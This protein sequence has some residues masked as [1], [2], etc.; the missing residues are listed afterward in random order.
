MDIKRTESRA[1]PNARRMKRAG[2]P[3]RDPDL[4]RL[5]ELARSV[6]DIREDRVAELRE[7][8]RSGTYHVE[9]DRI[10]EKIIEEHTPDETG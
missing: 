1:C 2:P 10:A 5:E 8:I 3:A 6:S 7:K 9:A 4:E